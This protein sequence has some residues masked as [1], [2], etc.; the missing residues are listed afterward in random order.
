MKKSKALWLICVML[1]TAFSF[2]GCC[3]NPVVVESDPPVF[4]PKPERVVLVENS[5]INEYRLMVQDIRW[6]MWASFAEW[7]TGII[8]QET[9]DSDIQRLQG[10]IDKYDSI[11]EEYLKKTELLD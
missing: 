4:A 6:M 10:V 2:S 3:S 7:K 9:Y 11:F 1:I 8:D 5:N